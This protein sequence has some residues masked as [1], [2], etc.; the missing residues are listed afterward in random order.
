V[1]PDWPGREGF[2][3][4]MLHAAEYRNGDPFRGQRVLVVGPGCSGMEIADDLARSGAATVWLAVRT[5]P[6]LIP[7]EGPGGVPGDMLGAALVH[8]PP[9]IGDA[10]TRFGRKAGIGDLTQYGL[11]VPEEGAMTRLRRLGATP[12][13][14]DQEV[15]E[16]IR[17]GAVEIV[18]GVEALDRRTVRLRDGSGLDP[19]VVICATGYRCGLEPLVGHLG[20]LD[21]EG[22]PRAQG[23]RAAAPGLRFIGYVPRPGALGSWG[24]QAKRAAKAIR[25]EVR[26]PSA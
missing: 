25:R 26:S 23:A 12:A 1:T 18:A 4:R 7:R 17:A 5:P 9:R 2:E 15:V 20:V 21:A 24:R 3:G 10:V 16:S 19:D 8:L 11:P 13:I 6:N 14:V 22:R